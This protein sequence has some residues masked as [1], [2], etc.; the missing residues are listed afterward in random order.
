LYLASRSDGFFLFGQGT[1]VL[2]KDAVLQWSTGTPTAAVGTLVVTRVE[3]A[4]GSLASN[5][6]RGICYFTKATGTGPAFGLGTGGDGSFICYLAG[7]STTACRNAVAGSSQCVFRGWRPSFNVSAANFDS[8][9]SL[10][11]NNAQRWIYSGNV[12]EVWPDFDLGVVASTGLHADPEN[13]YT[14]PAGVSFQ[15]YVDSSRPIIHDL[16]L[17]GDWL[18][19]W[20]R[21]TIVDGTQA[22]QNIIGNIRANWF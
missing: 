12:L 5:N 1:S 7:T 13:E 8:L 18:S 22:R 20:I 14:A 11:S 19:L 21:Q 17:G 3:I 16:L 6:G 4:S 15:P 9:G 2:Q 10:I